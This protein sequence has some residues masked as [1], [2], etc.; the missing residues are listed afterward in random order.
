MT[1]FPIS[2]ETET[3]L[4]QTQSNMQMAADKRKVTPYSVCLICRRHLTASTTWSCSSVCQL[5]SALATQ[6]SS[7][8]WIRSLLSGRAVQVMHDG[9]QSA[10]SAVLFG[11]RNQGTVLGPLLNFLNTAPLFN[12]KPMIICTTRTYSCRLFVHTA[13]SSL[14]QR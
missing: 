8:D 10:T 13:G 1:A 5:R 9:E 12:V 11:V 2:A 7:L 4:D 3:T 6:R 14:A